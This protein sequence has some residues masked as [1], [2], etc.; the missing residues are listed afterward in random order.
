MKLKS[1]ILGSVLSKNT[2][3][4]RRLV[5]LRFGHLVGPLA[6]SPTLKVVIIVQSE[7]EMVSEKP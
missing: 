5:P 2:S 4:S 7:K 6:V 3:Y 1:S